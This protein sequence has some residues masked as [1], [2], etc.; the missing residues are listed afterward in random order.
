MVT[1]GDVGKTQSDSPEE[2]AVYC[3]C[4][5][6]TYR[7]DR[8]FRHTGT[9]THTHTHTHTRMST[10]KTGHYITGQLCPL[11]TLPFTTTV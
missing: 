9:H 7:V 1:T 6:T 5:A 11:P 8:H 10:Y 4:S 3:I 2:C